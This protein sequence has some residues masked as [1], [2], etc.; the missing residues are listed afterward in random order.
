M[1]PGRAHVAELHADRDVR[2]VLSVASLVRE[3]TGE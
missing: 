2:P 3:I 1:E